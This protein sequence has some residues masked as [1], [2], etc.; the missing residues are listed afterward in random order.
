MCLR[1][2]EDTFVLAK[3]MCIIPMCT[4]AVREVL[5]LFYVLQWPC[6]MQFEN[7]DFVLDSKVRCF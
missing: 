2:E 1:D 5:G 3:T 7:V 4:V 6:D